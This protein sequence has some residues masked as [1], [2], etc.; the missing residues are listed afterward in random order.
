MKFK[1]IK[2]VF[3]MNLISVEKLAGWLTFLVKKNAKTGEEK[4]QSSTYTP[5]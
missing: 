2:T 3:L 5:T 1:E 4:H